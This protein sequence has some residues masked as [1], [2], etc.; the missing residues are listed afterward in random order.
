MRIL[1][2]DECGLLKE[3]IP[4]ISRN[5]NPTERGMVQASADCEG[6]SR[7][8]LQ[9]G[10][11]PPPPSMRQTRRR[12]VLGLVPVDASLLHDGGD[13]QT[14]YAD[15]GS[16]HAFGF[17]ALRA[18]GTV[19]AWRGER[20]NLSAKR[21]GAPTEPGTYR[22]LGSTPSGGGGVLPPPDGDEMSAGRPLGI[23]AAS[24]GSGS[25]LAACVDTMGRL[26][27]LD[28]AR[29]LAA[30]G[31]VVARYGAFGKGVSASGTITA[32]K[33]NFENKDVASALA[34]DPAGARVAVGGRERET[35][36]LDVR[37]GKLLWKAK[38]LKPDPQTLLQQ[39]IWTTALQF[40]DL[41]GGPPAFGEGSSDLL[42]VGTAYRQFRLYDVRAASGAA[43]QRRPVLRTRD[44]DLSH[45]ITALCRLGGHSYAVGDA[46]GDV[47]AID[48]RHVGRGTAGRYA[49]AGGS[50]KELACHPTLPV[51][52]SVSYDRMLRTYDVSKRKM[53]DCVYLKQRLTSMLFCDDPTWSVDTLAGNAEAIAGF[54]EGGW[55]NVAACGDINEEDEVEDYM[56]SDTEEGSR[57]RG[58]DGGAVSDSSEGEDFSDDDDDDDGGA[59]FSG[60]E[61]GFVTSSPK[62]PKRG[63]ERSSS[64]SKRV[65]K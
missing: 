22:R 49:G 37:T 17:A 2:G 53:L 54:G 27:V 41:G 13:G 39:P 16:D 35:T 11:G 63:R 25:A 36:L 61:E 60:Q 43:Q 45:R 50:I 24:P 32:T 52:T 23:C 18:D 8:D 47:H 33:G 12:G 5:A 65:R 28:L 19:E 55:E 31:A 30:D 21:K 51:L 44:G 34:M 6:V 7:L 9:F 62:H 57:G 64:N 4:E 46:S 38:N 56:D 26:S 42:A 3:V 14:Q 20:P 48:L 1:T 15:S 40:A 59:D 10:S 58:S 29:D